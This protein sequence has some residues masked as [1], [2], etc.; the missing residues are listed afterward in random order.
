[1]SKAKWYFPNN[2]GGLAAGFNDSSIDTFKGHRLSSLVR[3]IV[4]NSLDAC[5][6][7]TE[8]VTVAFDI[9]SIDKSTAPEVAQLKEHLLLAKETAKKQDLAPAVDFYD[10]AV[11][12]IDEKEKI[13]FLCIHDSNTTGLTGP[14]SGPGG[15]WFALT[16]GAGLSQKTSA[17]SLGSFGH[18][19]KAP[20]AN[21]NVRSLFYLTKIEQGN[22]KEYRFQGKSILQSYSRS[23]HE[24]TQ[25]TGFYGIQDGCLP[26]DGS[27]IPQWAIDIRENFS[28]D[29]GTS[30]FV[31]HTI[32]ELTSYP[33]IV[34]TAIANFFYAIRKGSLIVKI[35]D[36]E[37][38]NSQNIE[39]KYRFYKEKLDEEFNEVDKDYLI[40]CFE[41]IETVVNCTHKGEQQIPT[42]GRI[43]WYIRMNEEVE[44]RSVAIA[45][46]NGML[47]TRRAP[48]LQRFP[49]LKPFDLFVCVTGDGSET[50][51]TLENPE[52]NNFAFDRID[53][54][55]KRKSAEKKYYVFSNAVRELLKRFAEYSSEDR[56]TVDELQDLFSEISDSPEDG[57]GDLERGKHIQIENG[58]YAFKPRPTPSDKPKPGDGPPDD[59]SGRGARGGE[60]KQKRKGGGIPDPK[61][62]KPI[63]GPSAPTHGGLPKHF[64]KLENLRMRATGKN[65]AYVYFDSPLTGLASIRFKK[66]GEIGSEPINLIVEGKSVTA[67]D[68]EL[69]S[70][71]RE[72]VL[73][74][75]ADKNVDFA[76]E[77]EA[78][79]I[80]N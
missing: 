7:R 57:R 73:V 72:Y 60:K 79:E 12:L 78:H 16:K 35:G 75:F 54:E 61:G 49:N 63:I 41:A 70:G 46:E 77:A 27:D 36:S 26:L 3:E 17:S 10:R 8:P 13:N 18:G 56:V 42:F 11:G 34:I 33:S 4:Q 65:Q 55:K 20:F 48:A 32:F 67:V 62:G 14:I 19:S 23:E 68:V 29:T 44:S 51:K 50:L 53:D 58:N 25:G 24:M 66:S 5:L 45:R 9:V 30:I 59:L 43:D 31:P 64:L 22:K 1:M 80:N 52:H 21:S 71:Q 69:V 37:V 2:G 39:E 28:K 47:I 38:L 15:A 6:M 76:I 74:T 40:D